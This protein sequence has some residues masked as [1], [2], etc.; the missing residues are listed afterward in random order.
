MLWKHIWKLQIPPKIRLF[1]WSLSHDALPTKTNLFHRH[2]ILDIICPLC[3][4][5]AAETTVH[6]FLYCQWTAAIW[7][8]PLIN[9]QIPTPH[10]QHLGDWLG[11]MLSQN[12]NSPAFEVVAALLW[13]I[14]KARNNFIFQ[15]Q[16]PA[17]LR[18]VDLSLATVRSAQLS[19]IAGGIM[20]KTR[21]SPE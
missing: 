7:S 14:W 18:V 5:D 12:Q 11:N 17:P 16:R 10:I 6:T 20:T 19:S 15:H 3:S 2:I 21:L 8:H 4:T 13:N 9:I 1:L